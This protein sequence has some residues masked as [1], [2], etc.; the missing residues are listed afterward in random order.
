M[1]RSN[2]TKLDYLNVSDNNLRDSGAELIFLWV[3]GSSL[4]I[5]D[6]LV[7]SFD[8]G[9]VCNSADFSVYC[10]VVE[11]GAFTQG[12]YGANEEPLYC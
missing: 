1:I 2:Q 11:L 9:S 8:T 4:Q 5:A 12:G 3:D 7:S 6:T 10:K